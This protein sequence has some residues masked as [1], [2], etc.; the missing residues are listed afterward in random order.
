MKTSFLV[1]SIFFILI[2]ALS[3]CA[4]ES[5]LESERILQSTIEETTPVQ[6]PTYVPE[7]ISLFPDEYFLQD[8][9]R[10]YVRKYRECYYN[11]S[12]WFMELYR[13]SELPWIDLPSRHYGPNA[14]YIETDEM[15][16][17]VLIQ[18]YDIPKEVFIKALEKEKQR[19]LH[20]W[21]VERGE[22][23]PFDSEGS[24]WPNPD[25]I[26]TFDNEIINAYYRRE[27]PVV[28][29]P[30]TYTTFESYEEYMEAN[31]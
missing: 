21:R 7:D 8:V 27:N 9:N 14:E 24:E 17:V 4:N 18:H 16:I 11:Y 19:W 30:G 22:D 3:G 26:Y 5:P 20:Y 6:W 2:G 23:I 13:D 28:P 10:G 1:L 15:D 12:N 31:P 25:I 29:E